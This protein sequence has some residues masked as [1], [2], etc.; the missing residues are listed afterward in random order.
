MHTRV[1]EPYIFLGYQNASHLTAT[2]RD[3]TGKEFSCS[4][5][6]LLPMRTL[7]RPARLVALEAEHAH[8][9][10]VV[11]DETELESVSESEKPS[12]VVQH[13]CKRPRQWE[14]D[15]DRDFWPDDGADGAA[16]VA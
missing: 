7:T 1:Q 11:G 3:P 12:E 4:V 8:V 13:G 15:W 10:P 14:P 9:F 2:L 6:N 5:A 16:G